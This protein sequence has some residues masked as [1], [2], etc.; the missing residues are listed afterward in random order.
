[1]KM[2]G[3]RTITFVISTVLLLP[4]CG[5]IMDWGKR[6]LYQGE[7]LN[8]DYAIPRSFMRSAHAYDQFATVARFDVLWLS[9]EVRT[10]YVDFNVRLGGRNPD[11]RALLLKK[12]QDE[13]SHYIIFYVLTPQDI[14]LGEI[15]SY[16][17][18]FLSVD[19]VTFDAIEVKSIEPNPIYRAFLGDRFTRFRTVYQVKFDARDI[20]NNQLLTPTTKKISLYFRSLTREL[21]LD[22]VLQY[23]H[24][25]T[26]GNEPVVQQQT[27][28]D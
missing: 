17:L 16:W 14:A 13:N 10:S 23:P 19:D 24:E 4:G 1:M 9:P 26:F 25:N 15:N 6:T 20:H 11:Q 8:A 28:K 18:L 21:K 3:V 22:W 7:V 2:Q 27:V 5:R 12:Q